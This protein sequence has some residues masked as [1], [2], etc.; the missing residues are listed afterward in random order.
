M[1]LQ[2]CARIAARSLFLAAAAMLS[3]LPGDDAR[4]AGS[5]IVFGRT[6]TFHE[7]RDLPLTNAVIYTVRQGT[8]F[9]QETAGDGTSRYCGDAIVSVPFIGGVAQRHCVA[10]DGT[11]L[12]GVP[13]MIIADS[14]CDIS[15]AAP[16]ESVAAPA[17]AQIAASGPGAW[18]V[19]SFTSQLDGSK[20]FS[21]M[22][23]SVTP[24]SD[25]HGRADV[26]TLTVHCRGGRLSTSISWPLPMGPGGNKPYAGTVRWKF[27]SGAVMSELWSE[28]DIENDLFSPK[29]RSFVEQLKRATKLVV[30]A[31][32]Y[33]Y[34]M[35]EAVFDVTGADAVAAQA[36]A[37]CPKG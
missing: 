13:G 22:L 9:T 30:D 23:A 31:S 37:G 24:V 35:V 10:T 29:P 14:T 36:L 8:V 11:G 15:D 27:D 3:L 6:C 16:V 21:A 28:G 34:D 18:T 2:T 32:P 4:A 19:N 1:T 25:A 33:R 12:A 5:R 7:R 17:T 26:A 20:S